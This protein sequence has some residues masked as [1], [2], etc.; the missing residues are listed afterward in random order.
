[1]SHLDEWNDEEVDLA[2]RLH[3]KYE[4]LAKEECWETQKSC[5]SKKFE[6]LPV[7]NQRVMVR[8]ASWLLHNEA[9][10]S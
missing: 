10:V 4:E 9:G 5:K 7:E 1:M 8:L 2:I 3:D 6:E